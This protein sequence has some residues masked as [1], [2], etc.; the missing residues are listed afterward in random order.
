MTK[1]ADCGR[2]DGE[3]NGGNHSACDGTTKPDKL[4]VAGESHD[5][6]DDDEDDQEEEEDEPMISVSYARRSCV[7]LKAGPA[8]QTR[9]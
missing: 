5:D 1:L 7:A 2:T 6:D 4:V 9:N 3:R 8:A